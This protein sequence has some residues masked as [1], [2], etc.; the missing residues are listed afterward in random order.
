MTEIENAR[1]APEDLKDFY[2]GPVVNSAAEKKLALLLKEYSTLPEYSCIECN[3]VNSLSLFGDRPIHIAA[4]RGDVDALKL[5]LDYGA[6]IDCKGE[7]GCTPLHFAVEQ[8]KKDAVAYLLMQGANA[9]ILDDDGLS[10]VGVASLLEENEILDLFKE[11]KVAIFD[12][13][14]LSRGH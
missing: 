3:D 5:L 4:T 8:G 7:H 14:S 13:I 6:N 1:G 10:P 9:E 2:G 11:G 12:K